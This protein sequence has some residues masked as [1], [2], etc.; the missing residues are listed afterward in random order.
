MQGATPDYP[1]KLSHQKLESTE[2]QCR[3]GRGKAADFQVHSISTELPK[4]LASAL[5][6]FALAGTTRHTL[7]RPWQRRSWFSTPKHLHAPQ[8]KAPPVFWKGAC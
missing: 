4:S 7:Q 3:T 1:N 8:R 6:G 2:A 5:N